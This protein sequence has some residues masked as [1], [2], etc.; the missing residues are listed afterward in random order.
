[1]SM[2]NQNLP[3]LPEKAKEAAIALYSGKT[4]AIEIRRKLVELP[5]VAKALTPVERHVFAAS[6][7]TQISDISDEELV[8]RTSQM[9]KFIAMDVGYNVPNDPT[10]WQYICTRLVDLLKRYYPKMTLAD[11]K[12]AFELSAVGELD[13]HLP[14]DGKGNPDKHHYQQF[15]ADYFGKILKAYQAK[16]TGIIGKAYKALPEPTREISKEEKNYYYNYTLSGFVYCFLHFKYRGTL[17]DNCT[18]L[19]EMLYYDILV[20]SGLASGFDVTDDDK[21]QAM[22]RIIMSNRIN[23]YEQL[24]VSKKG[25]GHE[26]VQADARIIARHNDLL[27]TFSQMVKDEINVF[28]YVK[29]ER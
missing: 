21:R 10:E 12:L 3:S 4:K 16:Q 1:M 20:K 2:T 9:F 26:K 25:I 17:P 13:E 14:K 7:K 27:A 5:E 19:S 28:D 29:F 11:V 8:K 15:N 23:R 24:S 22:S 6:T 18:V